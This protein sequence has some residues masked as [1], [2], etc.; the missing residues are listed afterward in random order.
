MYLQHSLFILIDIINNIHVAFAKAKEL[1]EL[2]I[3]TETETASYIIIYYF[4]LGVDFKQVFCNFQLESAQTTVTHHFLL[5]L[6]YTPCRAAV[7]KRGYCFHR[8]LI[9]SLKQNRAVLLCLLH[10][11]FPTITLL[12]IND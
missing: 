4:I 2:T 7:M 5:L 11:N 8:K 9:I 12:T 3:H 10:S 6:K 1:T